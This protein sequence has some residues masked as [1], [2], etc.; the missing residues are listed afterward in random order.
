[1]RCP[2]GQT[3]S[4]QLRGSGLSPGSS[5][6]ASDP[7]VTVLA[8]AWLGSAVSFQVSVPGGAAP[9]HV[10]LVATDLSG[11]RSIL[12]APL[13]ITPP[14]PS[15]TGVVPNAGS[16]NGGRM[17]TISGAGFAEGLRVVIGDSVYPDG[18]P[19]GCTVIDPATIQLTTVATIGG[20]HDVVVIDPTGIE[21]R[22]PGAFLVATTPVI[23]SVFPP[24]G[25][26]L[27]GTTIVLR[28]EE[29]APGSL[30]RIAGVA[31][32]E[33]FV[34]DQARIVFVTRPGAAGGPYVL[35]VEN[36]GGAIAT[37]TFTFVSEADPTI[38]SIQPARGTTGGGDEVTIHGSGFPADAQVRFG[39][40][41]DTGAGGV[42]ALSVSWVDASTLVVVTPP[43]PKGTASVLVR[44][45]STGQASALAGAFEY[46]SS[47][48][49][50]S[51]GCSVSPLAIPRSPSDSFAGIWWLAA[52]FTVLLAR[53]AGER[54]RAALPVTADPIRP[55]RATRR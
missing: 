20:L 42:N 19:W 47:G 3:T 29:F 34:D 51:G 26:S 18:E 31:Q 45:P 21:A 17:V 48:G 1:M 39:A 6:A 25:H 44:G 12:P 53:V 37:S 30:V 23:E 8:T 35:E 7:S 14:S 5:L 22:A 38:D 24:A 32:G 40:D 46:R 15:I 52:L 16:P 4:L 41:P 27:G 11:A 43:G 13:E 36:P 54:S 50:G 28:G 2:A 33:A 55:R 10:D 9:G 49:G